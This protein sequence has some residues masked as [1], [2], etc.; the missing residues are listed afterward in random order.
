MTAY[1]DE[2][3]IQSP[4]LREDNLFSSL[5]AFLAQAFEKTQG[6]KNWLGQI[7]P[8]EIRD[9]KALAELPVL[10]KS[11]LMNLQA[12]N[13]PFGG[14][15][16]MEALQGNRVF[17]SPGPIWEPQGMG[18]DPWQSARALW[19]AGVRAGDRV[20][21]CFSY[22]M[23]PGAFILD[24]GARAL[25][26]L[27]FPA[28]VGNTESQ[29]DAAAALRSE[30]YTG[31]PD[32]LKIILDKAT[33]FGKDLSG[34]RRALVSGGALFPSLRKE[35][36]DRGIDVLQAF[37]TADIGVIAYE[38]ASETGEPNPGM[39]I[40]ENMIVEIVRPGTGIPVA[41]GEVGEIVV[42]SLN[43]AY[44]LVR[45]GTGDLSAF[46]DGMSPCGRTGK[47]INGWMGRADQRTKIK[48]MFVDPKQIALLSTEHPELAKAR[49]VVFR[50]DDEDAMLLEVEP[51]AG[52]Q[53]DSVAI[54]QTLT[55]ITKLK[56]QVVIRPL[57][58]LP[59]DGK[60]IS[61]E[62]DYET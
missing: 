39:I 15:A 16:N 37:A 1:F 7:D 46:M 59:N 55:S 2:L 60:V 58:S 62:R 31:T 25:G 47:R 35:Y 5:P 43:P 13:P 45:F 3:E 20:Q 19:A 6:L 18:T 8:S 9:R 29:V 23:T 33:E 17:M 34:F 24:E 50:E 14:L 21:N 48:G 56:G 22:H 28:G 49:L 40:N 51:L 57:G 12:E 4:A 36:R 54:S 26:C 27:V 61:D 42:T 41:D 44:P 11:E 30:V 10:R 53:P 52:S 38:S 32:F